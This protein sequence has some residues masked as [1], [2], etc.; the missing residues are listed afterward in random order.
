MVIGILQEDHNRNYSVEGIIDWNLPEIPERIL[1]V[2]VSD[3]IANL[4]NYFA[5]GI[6]TLFLAVG[7]NQKRKS[8][9]E[10]LTSEGFNFPNVQSGT[11][12]IHPSAVLRNGNVVAPFAHIGPLTVIGD[13]NIINTGSNLEHE[14]QLG[15]HCHIAPGSIVC[16]RSQIGDSVFIGAG[17][18]V[19]DYRKIASE[20]TVGAGAIVIKDIQ[21]PGSTY[22]GNPAKRIK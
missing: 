15:S 5:K 19:I 1:G 2:P 18:I 13:N 22:V 7:D 8:L 3:T 20:C 17:V 12:R 21:F 11:S 16:G 4:R 9:F 6:K 14:T 10:T